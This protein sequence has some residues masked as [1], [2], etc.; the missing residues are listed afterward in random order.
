MKWPQSPFSWIA[1]LKCSRNTVQLIPDTSN[2][3]TYKDITLFTMVLD[4]VH[5]LLSK[6]WKEHLRYLELSRLYYL[7]MQKMEIEQHLALACVLHLYKSHWSHILNQKLVDLRGGKLL[8]DG[9]MY[10]Y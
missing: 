10:H 7:K 3:S 5:I 4:V 2:F 1:V 6:I 8:E 9:E